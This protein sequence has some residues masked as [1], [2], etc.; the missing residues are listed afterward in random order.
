M[1]KTDEQ[2][3]HGTPNIEMPQIELDEKLESVPDYME[4]TTDEQGNLVY[5]NTEEEPELNARTYVAFAAMVLLNYVQVF[6]LQGPPAVV[7]NSF[8]QFGVEARCH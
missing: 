7:R 3:N 8:S 4:K 6:A 1:D 2:Q 5:Q